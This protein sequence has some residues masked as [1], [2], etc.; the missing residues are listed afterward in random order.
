[1]GLFVGF[2]NLA[3]IRTN[4]KDRIINNLGMFANLL[5]AIFF[6]TGIILVEK[7]PQGYLGLILILSLVFIN[8]KFVR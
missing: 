6:I 1:M 4:G 3:I 2:L 5:T 8:F 7:S